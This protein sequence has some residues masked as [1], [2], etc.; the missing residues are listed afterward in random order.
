MSDILSVSSAAVLIDALTVLLTFLDVNLFYNYK[1]VSL[2]EWYEKYRIAAAALDILILIIGF[3]II[4]YQAKRLK[5][6]KFSRMYY[7]LMIS[8]QM[9]HDVLFYLFFTVLPN[10]LDIFD[11]FKKYAREDGIHAIL[12]DSLM[13]IGTAV[14]Y[15]LI[16]YLGLSKRNSIMLLLTSI[17]VLLYILYLK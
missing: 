1:S 3:Y 15:Q 17:Y 11:F 2:L 16:E 9:L 12:S 7:V 14:V 10:G 6:R 5:I 8:L 4:D 13:M